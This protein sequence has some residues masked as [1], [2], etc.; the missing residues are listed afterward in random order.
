MKYQSW[1]LVLV[2]CAC[3]AQTQ[4]AAPMALKRLNATL[5]ASDGQ[6]ND[7]FG[8]VAVGGDVAAV[9]KQENL[10]SV[11]LYSRLSK[12]TVNQIATLS[13]SDGA[14]LYAVAVGE[15][16][17]LV[18]AGAPDEAVGNNQNQG[19]VYVFLEPEGG[20][21]GNIAETAKL[22]ASD[23]AA[24]DQL[25][26]SVATTNGVI[27]AG[28]YRGG[29][30]GQGEAYV[31]VEPRGG[32]TGCTETAQLTA[33]NGHHGD[34]FGDSV[35]VYGPTV[36]VGATAAN[37]AEGIAYVFRES[38]GGWKTMTETAQLSHQGTRETFGA[39]AI[40]EKTIAVG[41][42]NA[43][44][45]GAVY[46]YTQP[47]DGWLNTDMPDA[48]LTEVGSRCLGGTGVAI[49]VEMIAVGDPCV[50]YGPGGKIVGDSVVY[51]TPVNGWQNSSDGI[52]LRPK[53]AQSSSI[54]AVGKN[55]VIV[56][57]PGTTIG[58]SVKQGAAFI[59]TVPVQ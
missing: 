47:P 56:G 42:G 35:S 38:I 46:I 45:G 2:L 54:V 39:V 3:S 1:I 43:P 10:G 11:Y 52:L 31:Y 23:G 21:T 49:G 34:F 15:N 44:S 20:W 37:G 9:A 27:V 59:F 4:I 36:V 19:A 24:N 29:A 26:F 28:A 13:A 7:G 30:Q 17:R 12:G 8:S 50:R 33:S 16:G 57:A 40:L 18:V 32:W 53:G 22:T 14:G 51:L 48:T 25:G 58:N 55:R 41:A 5:L 6:A